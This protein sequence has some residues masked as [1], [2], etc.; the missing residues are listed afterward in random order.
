MNIQ[1]RDAV[2]A[3]SSLVFD[4][5]RLAFQ[6]YLELDAGWNEAHEQELHLKRFGIQRFRLVVFEGLD[7]GYAATAVYGQ[8]DKYPPSLYLHQLMLL[9]SH[10]SKGIGSIVLQMLALEA[11]RLELPLRFRV[12]RVNPRALAFYVANGCQMVDAS[13]K[14]FTMELRN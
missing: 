10:Q 9:P 11:R 2:T 12:L 14:H 4:M 8:I 6:K 3:D 13:D 1:L 7:V 5:R